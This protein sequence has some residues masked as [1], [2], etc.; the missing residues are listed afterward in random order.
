MTLPEW[1]QQ[2][3][4]ELTREGFEVSDYQGFP[5]VKMPQARNEAVKLLKFKTSLSA[6][7][8]IYGEGMLF[9][10]AVIREVNRNGAA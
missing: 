9:L 2:L 1:T 6:D 3:K 5:L 8:R 4:D 10:P 7:R